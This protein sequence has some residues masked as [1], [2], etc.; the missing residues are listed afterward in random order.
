MV[1][2]NLSHRKFFQHFF[3][4]YINN[5]FIYF[6]FNELPFFIYLL[7]IM[8]ER[9]E[10]FE[11]GHFFLFLLFVNVAHGKWPIFR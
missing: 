6:P 1:V 5:S 8:R 2:V 10:E 9:N 11:N 3:F 4:V 7:F